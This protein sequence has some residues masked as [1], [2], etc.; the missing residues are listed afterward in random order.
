MENEAIYRHIP[1]AALFATL[2]VIFPVFFHFTGLGSAF[3]P[4]FI[5]VIMG[6]MLLPPSLAAT[7]AVATP[8]VSFLFTGM[9]PLYPPILVLV[10]VE[11]LA[12][13]LLSSLLYYV[14]NY[15]VWVTL[16]IAMG[17]D[18]L[19]L[20]GFVYVLAGQLGFPE[21]FYSAG[22]V[23]YGLPGILLIFLIIPLTLN[24]LKQRYPQILH[25]N[26]IGKGKHEF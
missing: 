9:P 5:P 20:F 17:T 24:F 16:I 23:L 15:S 4:M 14:K 21:R 10:V 25:A 18:R 11:L 26:K 7:I 19:I 1:L 3:L 6:S 12:V 13:S 8:L 2:G 22:A